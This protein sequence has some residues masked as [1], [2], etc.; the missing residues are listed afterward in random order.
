MKKFVIDLIVKDVKVLNSQYSLLI[1][2]SECVLPEMLPGQF[3]EVRVDNSPSTFLRRPISINFYDPFANEVWLL[4]QKVGEGTIKLC[5]ACK[6]DVINAILPLGNTFTLPNSKSASLLLVG[7]GVGTAPLLYFG[8][9]LKANGYENVTFLLGGRSKDNLLQ[10]DEFSKYGFV[11]TTTEDNSHGEKGFV[12]QHSILQTQKFQFVYSCGPTP[13]MKA[14]AAYAKANN[15]DCEVSLE[16][17]MACGIGACLC[18]V[19]ESTDGHVCV[20]TDGPVFNISKLQW[21]I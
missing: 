4:I 20:C 6:G 19:T 18:C 12:T 3:A 16:N 14:V 10:L 9:Y 5:N 2:T 11:L 15:I 17:T 8:A 1:L 7:G 13:M 21:Q